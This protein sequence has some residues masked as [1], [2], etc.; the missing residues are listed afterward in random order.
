MKTDQLV[1]MLEHI[2]LNMGYAQD[3]N[4]QAELVFSHLDKFWEQRMIVALLADHE[5]IAKL[6]LIATAVVK[7][8]A[9]SQAL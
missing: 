2:V 5:S 8:L 9:N 6:S 1:K 7:K 4:E 3:A